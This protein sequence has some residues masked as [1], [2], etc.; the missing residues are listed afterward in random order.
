MNDMHPARQQN[1]SLTCVVPVYNEG[2]GIVDFLTQLAAAL[3]GI[4]DQAR[5]LVIDDGSTDNTAR[6]VVNMSPGLPVGLISLSR[7]FG[8]ENAI[9]AGLD[10][11][12]ADIV[13]VMDADF[14]HPL[15]IL[16]EFVAKWRLGYDMVYGVRHNRALDIRVYRILSGMF[17]KVMSYG[18]SVKIP[19]D[20]G[21]FRLMDRCV[22]MA[23]RDLPERSKFMKGLYNWVGFTKVAVTFDVDERKCGKSKFRFFQLYELAMTGITSF[24]SFP[25]RIWAGIGAV[26]SGLSLLYSVWIITDTLLYGA[27]VAGW[28]TLVVAIFFLGGIQLLSIGILGEYI[29]RIFNE[30]K[31]RPSYIIARKQGLN[32]E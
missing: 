9:A 24:S 30:V 15:S 11:A 31:G 28:P 2:D 5:I 17:Y 20:A 25:L 27:N 10:H 14:Q 18:A 6:E 29:A 8:K 23:L 3:R 12:N 21:D 22:V 19:R 7:N 32:E 26:I 1:P 4:T 16:P 13:I